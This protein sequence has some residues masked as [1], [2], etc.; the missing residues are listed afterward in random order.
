[1]NRV[2]LDSN[3]LIS[4]FFWNGNEREVLLKCKIKN[5][6]SVLS[7][8][9][10]NETKRVLLNKFDLP[11]EKIDEYIRNVLLFSEIVAIKGDINVIKEDPSDNIILETAIRGNAE[12]IITGDNH[13]LKIKAY[14]RIT[15][16]PASKIVYEK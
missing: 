12:L 10:L 7:L 6:K 9:I 3:V 4:A 1:M 2:V 14:K 15:I 5:L 11:Q 8:E 16:V 13:L